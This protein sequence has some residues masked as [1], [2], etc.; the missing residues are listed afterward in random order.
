METFALKHHERYSLTDEAYDEIFENLSSFRI[1]L[2]YFIE[3]IDDIF[4]RQVMSPDTVSSEN[5][6]FIEKKLK[7]VIAF[8]KKIH[9]YTDWICTQLDEETGQ[10]IC[11]VEDLEIRKD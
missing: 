8:L 7:L 2:E 9:A 10:L 6:D 5:L 1:C 11:I 3:N 4:I